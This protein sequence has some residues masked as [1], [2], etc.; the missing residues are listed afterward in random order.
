MFFFGADIPI[1][2]IECNTVI[3]E[4]NCWI[5][6]AETQEEQGEK[7]GRYVGG[8]TNPSGARIKQDQNGMMLP[9]FWAKSPTITPLPYS[10]AIED[11]YA[12]LNVSTIRPWLGTYICTSRISK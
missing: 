2:Y 5:H 6:D 7:C 9:P 10:H 11:H 12:C 3:L 1:K 8:F 4:A